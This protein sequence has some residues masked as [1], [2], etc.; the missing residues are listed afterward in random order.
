MV[1]LSAPVSILSPNPIHLPL[2]LCVLYLNQNVQFFVSYNI[3]TFLCP[4]LLAPIVVWC[5]GTIIV[6]Y[7]YYY[8]I[9]SNYVLHCFWFILVVVCTIQC[10]CLLKFFGCPRMAINASVQYNGGF[11][12][13]ILLTQCHYHRGTR[14]NA[15]RRF[16]LCCSLSSPEWSSSR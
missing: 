16:C 13:I 2:P 10:F 6:N 1:V 7:Y 15:M 5:D 9:L 8:H 12:P 11:L 3:I 4:R 14:L